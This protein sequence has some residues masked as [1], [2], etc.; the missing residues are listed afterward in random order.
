MVITK[1]S[2][3]ADILKKSS[4]LLLKINI[5]R[6]SFMCV[7][8]TSASKAMLGSVKTFEY[9]EVSFFS[10]NSEKT[11]NL[12]PFFTS[13]KFQQTVLSNWELENAFSG[14]AAFGCFWWRRFTKENLFILLFAAVSS[15]IGLDS[16]VRSAKRFQSLLH[17][18]ERVNEILTSPR[19]F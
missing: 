19:C 5:A 6:R 7:G 2:R 1:V 13:P 14:H 12:A 9:L 4:T 3:I 15:W 18:Q 11:H 16:K 8:C 17:G 10:L